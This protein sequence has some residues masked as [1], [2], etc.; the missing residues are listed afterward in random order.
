VFDFFYAYFRVTVYPKNKV[1]FMRRFSAFFR[2]WFRPASQKRGKNSI[3][4]SDMDEDYGFEYS[5]EEQD[6]EQVD[7]ENQYYTAKGTLSSKTAFVSSLFCFSLSLFEENED[8]T[9]SIFFSLSLFTVSFLI[10][11]A[12]WKT[13]RT[14]RKRSRR[15]LRW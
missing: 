10:L 14:L 13:R 15:S 9:N 2:F 11:Q 8:L 12:C 6:E 7:V 3:I 4:M 5:D 1:I